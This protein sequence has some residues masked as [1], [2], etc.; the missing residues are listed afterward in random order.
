VIDVARGGNDHLTDVRAM[1]PR[2]S[3]TNAAS[4][5][6]CRSGTA[7]RKLTAAAQRLKRRDGL[8]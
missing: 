3:P 1:L 8:Q 4:S 6:G 7:R 2:G 5:S